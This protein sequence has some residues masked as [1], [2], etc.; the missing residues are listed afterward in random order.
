MNEVTEVR[1]HSMVVGDL[2]IGFAYSL[3]WLVHMHTRRRFIK[4]E[5]LY[6]Y[7]RAR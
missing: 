7:R 2:E 5:S 6:G 3:L 1:F 4:P